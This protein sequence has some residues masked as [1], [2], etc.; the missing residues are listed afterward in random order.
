MLRLLFDQVGKEAHLRDLA[1]S[2][3][4]TPAAVQRELGHLKQ[5]GLV[6]SRR[7][8]NR[9]Y[10][11]ANQDHPLFPELHG[12]VVKTSGAVAIIRQA[13]ASVDGV[14]LSFIFGSTA[15]GAEA[16][17]SDVD[18]LVIG[19]AGLRKITPALHDA[20]DALSREINPHCMT[21]GEWREKTIHR[22]A[23]VSRLAAEPKLWLKGG[24]DE[25]AALER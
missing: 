6:L 22:D 21:T 7:D 2:A 23:F 11:R 15:A 25:L 19:S 9:L 3:G 8:G 4:L 14:D 16:A 1:R 20:V 12:L 17:H 5:T 10:F 18:I 13:I 24:P